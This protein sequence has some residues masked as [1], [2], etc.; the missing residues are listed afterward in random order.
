MNP[1][2]IAFFLILIL[3]YSPISANND[4]NLLIKACRDCNWVVYPEIFKLRENCEIARHGIF[5]RG[6]TRCKKIE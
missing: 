1:L 5:A 6:M 4:F 3:T 2:R